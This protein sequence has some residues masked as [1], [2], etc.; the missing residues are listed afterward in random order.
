[1]T[2]GPISKGI[3]VL[4]A[5]ER[6]WLIAALLGIL[7]FLFNI[8]LS[9]TNALT[10][11]ELRGWVEHTHK[12]LAGLQR[13]LATVHAAETG[14]RGFLLTGMP[15]YL[16]PYNTATTE[17][18]REVDQLA[19]LTSKFPSQQQ[20][21]SQIRALATEKMAELAETIRLRKE[22]GFEAARRAVVTQRGKQL[23]DGLRTTVGEM[24]QETY[25]LLNEREQLVTRISHESLFA[26]I[27]TAVLA[28]IGF[29][30]ALA[31]AQ[32][33]VSIRRKADE[34]WK[35]SYEQLQAAGRLITGAENAERRRIGRD[36][37]N[38]LVQLLNGIRFDMTWLHRRCTALPNTAERREI[39]DKLGDLVALTD[40]TVSAVQR[41][42]AALQPVPVEEVGL[43]S[44]I[45]TYAQNF[46]S[47]MG[48]ACAVA[49]SPTL[50]DFTFDEH[51]A[52]NIFRIIQEL[53]MNAARHAE[54]TLVT[55]TLTLAEDA[56]VVTVED[57][58]KGIT[59]EQMKAA[60]SHGIVSME[61]RALLIGGTFT[62]SGQPGV[63]TVAKLTIPITPTQRR[64]K[65]VMKVRS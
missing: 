39:I 10:I 1:M 25:R 30:M 23:M 58:G 51:T 11:M 21:V 50:D 35:Q 37:Q 61:E 15:E 2:I 64:E 54:A 28:L 22:R 60:K 56:V 7:L 34:Q 27:A 47:H 55:I 26:F 49:A 42:S 33:Y 8:Y 29:A 57:N 9:V 44:A 62:I 18:H 43:I 38:D 3:P 17:L 59:P 48:V 19:E 63:G 32:K 4:L 31:L 46:E 13:F 24:E 36:I 40:R 12:V 52:S 41:V 16:E 53:L 20:R 45:H 65:D 6:K 5:L 14:Q